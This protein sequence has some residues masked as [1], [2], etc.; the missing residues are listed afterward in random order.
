MSW[1]P[2]LLLFKAHKGVTTCKSVMKKWTLK[3]F[4]CHVEENTTKFFLYM[5]KE[6][7]DSN[8][9][10]LQKMLLSLFSSYCSS[11]FSFFWVLEAK[12][13]PHTVSA[14]I[15]CK[16]KINSAKLKQMTS[17]GSNRKHCFVTSPTAVWEQFSD[18]GSCLHGCKF[19]SMQCLNQ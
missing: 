9:Q 6:S 14:A 10:C 8:Q 3:M 2:S 19:Y 13:N 16:R 11:K 7:I 1:N 4:P 15:F 5:V 12:E 18:I 17:V